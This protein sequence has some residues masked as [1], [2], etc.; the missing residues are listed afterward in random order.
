MTSPVKMIHLTFNQYARQISMKTD[1]MT[2]VSE[3]SNLD[4]IKY[5]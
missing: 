4:Q 3:K 1:T 5:K 2:V